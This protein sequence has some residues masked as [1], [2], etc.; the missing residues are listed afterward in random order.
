[1]RATYR[2]LMTSGL[3]VAVAM[4]TGVAPARAQFDTPDL[5][6]TIRGVVRDL[7]G[8]PVADAR[9]FIFTNRNSQTRTF[10]TD[11]EGR[12]EIHGLPGNVDYEVRVTFNGTESETR[13]VTSF[14]PREDNVV[15]FELDL[16]LETDS[17]DE[18][19]VSFETF[20]GVTLR[21]EFALPVGVQAPIPV[22]LLLH[23]FGE[24]RGVWNALTERLLNGGWAVLAIDLRGHGQSVQ[25]GPQTLAPEASWRTDPLQLPLDLEPALDWIKTRPRLN[26]S[27]IAVIGSDV[28][29]G[30]ALIAGGRYSEVG[31]V[32]A[33]NP[34]LDEALAMAG[35]ARDFAPRTVQIVVSDPEVGVRVREYVQ[36]ASRVTVLEPP[37]PSNHTAVWVG[38]SDTIDEILRWLRDTY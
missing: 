19:T 21:G 2:F 22:A 20:D 32:V 12:Y 36:G 31:T 5:L 27:R 8:T 28:G 18:D 35:T 29:A 25:R 34:N 15:N 26:T 37:P 13:V 17:D 3:L 16:V 38:A 7:A 23:G 33:L 11:A 9:I 4:A 14:L 1:V 30:L 24:T 10:R 6:K